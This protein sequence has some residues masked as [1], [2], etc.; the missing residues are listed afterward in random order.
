L[1]IAPTST[2]DAARIARSTEWLQQHD[3]LESQE[4]VEASRSARTEKRRGRR[5]FTYI[6]CLAIDPNV[7]LFRAVVR[8]M[9]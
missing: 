6:V 1:I 7:D 9:A 4:V 5:G 8:R 2:P 3:C